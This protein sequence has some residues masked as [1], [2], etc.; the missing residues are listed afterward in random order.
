MKRN[1]FYRLNYFCLYLTIWED[2]FSETLEF[3]PICFVY[4]IHDA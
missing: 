3:Y 2:M 4:I 1:M